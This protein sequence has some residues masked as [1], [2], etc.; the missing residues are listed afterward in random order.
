MK[1][2]I[3]SFLLLILGCNK[4]SGPTGPSSSEIIF[5]DHFDNNSSASNWINTGDYR[6]GGVFEVQNGQFTRTQVGHVFYYNKKFS[7]ANG[8]YEFKAQGTWVFFWR[9]T[10]E[11]FTNGK[12]LAIVSSDSTLFYYECLWSGYVYGFHNN[13][14]P[15]QESANVGQFLTDNLNN[16]RINDVDST[17]RIYVNNKLVLNLVVSRDFRNKGYIEIGCNH[18]SSPTA[19]DDIIVTR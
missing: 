7:S 14:R 9:G 10:T 4:S 18:Q 11:D 8:T 2:T 19:F 15:R 17:A 16:I 13:S 5:E 3:F 12:A 1:L 6:G